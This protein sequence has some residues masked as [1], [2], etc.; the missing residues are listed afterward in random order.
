MVVFSL[1]SSSAAALVQG[2]PN[3]GVDAAK[4]KVDGTRLLSKVSDAF[5]MGG[6]N[7]PC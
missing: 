5:S 1:R 4:A 3:Q 2:Q 7:D 6:M